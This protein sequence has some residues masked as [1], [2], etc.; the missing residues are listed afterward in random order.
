[1]GAEELREVDE[2]D[3]S[4][5]D[6]SLMLQYMCMHLQ[7]PRVHAVQQLL[8]LARYFLANPRWRFGV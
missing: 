2:T 1:M 5:G 7:Q 6:Y 8:E 3:A 4:P